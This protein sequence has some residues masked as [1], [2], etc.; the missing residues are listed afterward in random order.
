MAAT[1][2]PAE[3]GMDISAAEDGGSEDISMEDVLGSKGRK[4]PAS[5]DDESTVESKTV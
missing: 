2:Q 1:E 3:G 5:A 4:A